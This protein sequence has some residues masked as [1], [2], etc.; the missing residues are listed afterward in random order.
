M[1]MLLIIQQCQSNK[2]Y[3]NKYKR[4]AYVSYM[5]SD[6]EHLIGVV[7]TLRVPDS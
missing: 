4:V 2:K 1:P 5:T 7:G 6:L 3:N